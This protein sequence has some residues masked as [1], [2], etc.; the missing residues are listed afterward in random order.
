MAGKRTPGPLSQIDRPIDVDDGTFTRASMARPGP[1]GLDEPVRLAGRGDSQAVAE[2]L[3]A[4]VESRLFTRNPGA[5]NRLNQALVSDADPIVP[6][7][8][9]DHVSRIQAALSVLG[10]RRIDGGEIDQK[11]Y[12]GSTA[13]AVVEF[14]GSCQPPVL[15]PQN[16]VDDIVERKT[17]QELDRKMKDVEKDNPPIPP[18]APITGAANVQTGPLGPR[19]Q[20]VTSYYQLCGL[21]TIGPARIRTSDL[22]SYTTFEGLIDLLLTRSGQQQVIVNHGNPTE[23]LLV[24]WCR[25]SSVSNTANSMGFFSKIAG[26]IEQGTANRTNPDFQ[27]SLDTLT[28]MLGISRQA[29]LR[30]A[31]KLV[32]VRKKSLV[33]HLRACNIPQDV[34]IRYKEAFRALMVTFHP[35]RLLYLV[36]RPVPFDEGRGIPDF[37]TSHNS[38]RAR[39]RILMDPNFELTTMA[40]IVQDNDGHENVDNFSFVNRLVPA[41]IHGW[42]KELIGQWNGA[43]TEFVIPVMWDNDELSYHFPADVGW[44]LK[45]QSV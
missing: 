10:R 35:V 33:L 1:I 27:D 32:Q 29:A 17:T 21:E 5:R 2:I 34:A 15:N 14:K 43:P 20:I 37:P 36:I 28:F 18:P 31:E 8:A 23:G 7:S 40:I 25:E 45:L 24:R 11:L 3:A 16:E 4:T 30:I 22:R 9:G 19:G 39:A 41:E 12:G 38:A 26:A 6:G 42:A 44:R 13:T